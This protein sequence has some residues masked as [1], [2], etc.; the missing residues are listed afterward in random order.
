MK[1]SELRERLKGI[2]IISITPFKEDGSFDA[3]GYEKNL[4]FLLDGGL[5]RTNST[6]VVGGSTGECGAMSTR[7]RKEVFDCALSF[8]DGEIPVIAGC[9]STNPDESIEL[10]R[11][12]QEHGAAGVM[13]LS[14]YYYPAKDEESIYQFYKK[15]SQGT[16]LG[17]LLYNNFEVMQIDVP[18]SVLKR[19]VNDFPNISG[20]K[21]CTPAFFKMTRVVQEI[22]DKISIVNGHGEFLEPYAALAG[23]SGFISSMSNFAP[24]RAIKIWNARSSGDYE[25]AKAVK[26]TLVPYMDLAI[27]YSG[28]GGE[29]KVISLLK[30]MTD[31]VGSCGGYPRV[32]CVP[33][34]E[35]EKAETLDVMKKCNLI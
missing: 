18:L 22:G 25:T 33:L 27:K 24:D 16:D 32:P 23:T 11:Y 3:K 8:L 1:P 5:N 15:L 17:I 28:M 13:A 6:I 2:S 9:N 20:M 31:T 35:A 26:N 29:Y 19:M 4:K 34:T 21:E 12:A 30:F 10:A 14:P 7:E